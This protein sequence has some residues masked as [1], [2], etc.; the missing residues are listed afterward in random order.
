MDGF[1]HI[2]AKG[3]FRVTHIVNH[4]FISVA[5]EKH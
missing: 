1:A 2:R 4:N 3:P 5:I